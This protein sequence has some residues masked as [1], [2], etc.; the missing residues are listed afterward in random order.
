MNCRLNTRFARFSNVPEPM[1]MFRRAT[2]VQTAVM[3]DLQRPK[4]D[5]EKA[6]ILNAP[7]TEE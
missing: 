3:P 2:D 6:A 5:G 4:F 1:Q 7:A